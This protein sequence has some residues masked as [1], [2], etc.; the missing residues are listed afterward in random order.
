MKKFIA[1]L[2]SFSMLFGIAACGG[3]STN[4]PQTTG[5]LQFDENGNVIFKQIDID[6]TTVVTGDDKSYLQQIISEFNTEYNGRIN[7]AATYTGQE[8]FSAGFPRQVANNSNVPDLIMDHQKD[9][10]YFKDSDLL[11]PFTPVIEQSKIDIDLEDYSAGLAQYATLGTDEVYGIPIDV[12]SMCVYY[13]KKALAEIGK[14]VPSTRAELLDVCAAAKAKGWLPVA[15]DTTG[16]FYVDYFFGTAIMQNGGSFYESDNGFK[17]DCYTDTEN[18][19]SYLNAINSLRE[20]YDKG[21]IVENTAS[22]TCLSRFLDGTALFYVDVPWNLNS[23]IT[24]Y[25]DKKDITKDECT[26]D[27]V[28]G[29]SLAK[30]FGLDAAS[31]DS[32]KIFGDSHFFAMCISVSDITKKAAICEFVKW[33]TQT[34]NAG[35]IWAD[36][37]HITASNVIRENPDYQ[38]KSSVSNFLTKFFPDPKYME[39]PGDSPYYE[40]TFGGMSGFYSQL[41]ANSKSGSKGE[42]LLRK[43]EMTIKNF[44]TSVNQKIALV[45]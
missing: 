30:W 26:K 20:M 35:S 34:Y 40:Q 33:F 7:V 4:E 39:C 42:E 36:A 43:D 1:V 25:A 45:M 27:Y 29:T 21:Y 6:L 16:N 5:E 23:V 18:R 14:T 32:N 3:G 24:A 19:K 11:Q 38:A 2:L 28:G 41:M 44:E 37:G 10:R 12:R 9:Y 13:N 17:T 31:E 15:V 22:S 8:T